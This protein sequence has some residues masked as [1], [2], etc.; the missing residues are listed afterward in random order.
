MPS[1]DLDFLN[2]LKLPYTD[3]SVFIETGTY[4]GETIFEMEKF[5]IELHTIELSEYYYNLSKNKYVGNKIKFHLGDSSNVL[6]NILLSITKPTI[7]FL[8]GHWSSENTA[9]GEKDCPLKEELMNIN[10]YFLYDGIIIIDDC[11][12]FGK[13]QKTGHNEDWS[14]I[15]KENLLNIISERITDYY[16][17]DSVC[18]KDDRLVIHIKKNN[19]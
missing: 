15:T 17:L 7:F 5:F 12:L 13:S 11:R 10:K 1:L 16:F 6:S 9:K 3:F 18:S 8:D 14:D 4:M 19:L 2:K